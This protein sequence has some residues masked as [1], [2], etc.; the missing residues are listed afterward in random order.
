MDSTC[1]PSAG[2]CLD[3]G[4]DHQDQDQEDDDGE[5]EEDDD[6]EGDEVNYDDERGTCLG[7]YSK[8]TLFIF[9]GV[10]DVLFSQAVPNHSKVLKVL[11]F[12]V[13]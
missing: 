4:P 5:E 12:N 1:V 2:L 8:G 13:I 6:E 11:R 10:A 3:Q 7:K 9:E